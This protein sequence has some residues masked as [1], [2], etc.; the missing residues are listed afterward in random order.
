MVPLSE[1]ARFFCFAALIGFALVGLACF[2]RTQ[3][4]IYRAMKAGQDVLPGRNS[5]RLILCNLVS[6]LGWWLANSLFDGDGLWREFLTA[7]RDTGIFFLLSG[8]CVY[9]ML[10]YQRNRSTREPEKHS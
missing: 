10:Q 6:L 7:L 3:R 8:V 2:V 4:C 9:Q 1:P 5:V